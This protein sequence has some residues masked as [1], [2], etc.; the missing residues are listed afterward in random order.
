MNNTT[1]DQ[2]CFRDYQVAAPLKSDE[3]AERLDGWRRFRDYQV[4]AP[5]KSASRGDRLVLLL[6]SATIK[7][8]PH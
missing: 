4:A 8:R 3:S 5:L 1:G 6:V 2:A 7:S